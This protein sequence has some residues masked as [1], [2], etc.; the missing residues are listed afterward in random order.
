MI[1]AGTDGAYGPQGQGY[2]PPYGQQ[3][4]GYPQ[5]P[6]GPAVGAYTPLANPAGNPFGGMPAINAS[7]ELDPTVGAELIKK[8]QMWGA[9][10][11]IG[12]QVNQTL[13]TGLN[14]ALASK[15]LEIQGTIAE[16]Y[17][18]TQDNIAQYQKEVALTQ[19]AV[20]EE[21]MF[22]QKDMLSNQILHE[23]KMARLEGATQARLAQIAENG[24]TQR[25]EI[26][27]M[28]DAFSRSGWDMGAPLSA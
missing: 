3:G 22:V 18:T 25:A 8:Q 10:G 16:K 19:L 21:G 20:Q 14:Y 17:Y 27:S 2:P 28:T 7:V 24:K 15:S 6:Q 26:L 1:S 12:S 11:M 4:Y 5:Q 9:I 23:Q 13:A